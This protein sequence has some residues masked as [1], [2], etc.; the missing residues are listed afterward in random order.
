MNHSES[1]EG[2]TSVPNHVNAAGEFS[3][4]KYGWAGQLEK[5][6]VVILFLSF[7]LIVATT[8]LATRVL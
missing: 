7:I 6:D 3:P 5:E 8:L 1:S 2:K 4:A